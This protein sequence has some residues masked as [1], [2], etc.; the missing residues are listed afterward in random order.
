MNKIDMQKLFAY[1]RWAD[2]RVLGAA[3]KLAP[4]EIEREMGSSFSSVFKTLEHI[5]AA[6]WVWLKRLNGIS[7]SEMFDG[8]T[9]K[10]LF[11]LRERWAINDLEWQALIETMNEDELTR[12]IAYQNLA[13]EK[14][15][16]LQRD[17]MQHVANHSTYHR[18]Q[19]VAL[20]RQLGAQGV[21]TDMIFFKG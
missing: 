14:L 8:H 17:I 10:S 13:G 20:M 7:P 5:L 9:C 4:E 21:E 11:E 18:G 3:E 1:T 15:A 12:E 6:Q 16:F 2:A 19:A